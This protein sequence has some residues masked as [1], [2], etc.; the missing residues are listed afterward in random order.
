MQRSPLNS[1]PSL[2]FHNALHDALFRLSRGIE[3][4]DISAAQSKEDLVQLVVPS[5]CGHVLVAYVEFTNQFSCHRAVGHQ[6]SHLFP[7]DAAGACDNDL[8]VWTE[9]NLC[10]F[11]DVGQRVPAV[12][13]LLGLAHIPQL[14][15]VIEAS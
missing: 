15:C 13:R 7:S 2:L 8:L 11:A 10:L 3:P 12:N 5:D 9:R 4:Q 1:F 6:L 14:H